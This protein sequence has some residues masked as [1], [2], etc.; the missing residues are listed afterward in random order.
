M[1]VVWV[2]V[3]HRW[4]QQPGLTMTLC[5]SGWSVVCEG[6]NDATIC[7]LFR[8]IAMFRRTLSRR[9][10]QEN[11][12]TRSERRHLAGVSVEQSTTKGGS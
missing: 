5:Y 11:Y 7:R 9:P 6:L 10:W 12:A 1:I 3:N 2:R 8:S 4:Q